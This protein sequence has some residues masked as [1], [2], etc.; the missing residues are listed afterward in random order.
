MRTTL[1]IKKVYMDRIRV[2]TKTVE[3]RKNS[4]YY[5][6]LFSKRIELLSLHYQRKERLLVEVKSVRLIDKPERFLGDISLP[7]RKIFAIKLG[8]IVKWTRP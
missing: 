8:C 4:P 2:G 7:T 1:R 6:A 5:R 3:F